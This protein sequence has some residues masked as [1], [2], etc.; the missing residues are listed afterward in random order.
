M[1]NRI[2]AVLGELRESG[3]TALAPFITIGFPDVP[4]SEAL[5]RTI[6]ESGG[7]MLE[8][9]VP[10]SDPLADGPT[11]Q[12]TRVESP[13]ILMGYY[14]P[15]LSYGP[16]RFLD[17]AAAAGLDGMI[18]PDLPTEESAQFGAMAADRGIHLI[19]ML[20]RQLR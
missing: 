19:P 6:L 15:Y 2:D 9:G 5:A 3:R 13:L 11:V 4:T 18:V 16:E 12:M 8:L 20:A 1:P 10:F 17:D 7:D 14:N